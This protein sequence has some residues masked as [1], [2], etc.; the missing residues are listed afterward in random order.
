MDWRWLTRAAAASL[1]RGT[2][3]GLAFIA[4]FV[5]IVCLAPPEWIHL[6]TWV[7]EFPHGATWTPG[8]SLLVA[9]LGV[10]ITL[11]MGPIALSLSILRRWLTSVWSL[12]VASGFVTALVY[13]PE[14]LHADHFAAHLLL[15][16]LGG[17]WFAW[18]FYETDL[19]G[20][21]AAL[22]VFDG[23]VGLW[24][25]L[26]MNLDVALTPFILAFLALAALPVLALLSL[27]FRRRPAPPEGA[28]GLP[29]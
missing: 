20:A 16:F 17:A 13:R 23:V 7:L 3:W 4:V 2:L 24:A 11:A 6:R 28:P 19:L 14:I 22:V 12:A 18:C 29:A 10:G 1:L 21:I 26:Q 27:H 25:L 15:V 8:L 5:S 9:D